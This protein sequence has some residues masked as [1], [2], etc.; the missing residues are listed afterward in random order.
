MLFRSDYHAL[1]AANMVLGGQYVSRVNLNLRQDKGVT[2]GARTAFEFRRAPGPFAL[3]VSVDKAATALAIRESMKEIAD[4]RGDR[5]ITRVELADGVAALTRGYARNFETFDH[6]ARAV[7]QLALFDLPETFYSEFVDRIEALT[8]EA[9][10]AA[11]A[12]HLDPA[13]LTTLVVGDIDTHS[14]ELSALGLGAPALVA[15]DSI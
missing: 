14:E 1:V 7:T 13:R 12:R 9:V 6:V 5:P 8:P 11:A 4:I 2:Y 15:P 3:S 10:M